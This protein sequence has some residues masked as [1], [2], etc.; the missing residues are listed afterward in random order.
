MF[1]HVRAFL[2]AAVNV[3][4]GSMLRPIAWS[5]ASVSEAIYFGRT[6]LRRCH[7]FVLRC[8]GAIQRRSLWFDRHDNLNDLVAPLHERLKAATTNECH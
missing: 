7:D 4:F 2:A 3:L 6:T 8:E 1:S 5:Q